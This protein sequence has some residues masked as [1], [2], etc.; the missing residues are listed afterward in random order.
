VTLVGTVGGVA[1][2]VFVSAGATLLA[3]PVPFMAMALGGFAGALIDS[4]LG[5]TLQARRWCDRCGEFTE[6]KIHDCGTP[7]TRA[8]GL[9][10]M[11]NDV[12]NAIC[13]A[14]G[15][16]VALLLS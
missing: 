11:N 16:L 15:A 4:V 2:A 5:G 1:G 12:V 7:T 3:W 8:G 6:R 14:T 13:C 10:G 9:K